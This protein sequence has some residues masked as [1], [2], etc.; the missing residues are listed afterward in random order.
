ME[1]KIAYLEAR[2][3]VLE[4]IFLND[5]E[6]LKTYLNAM[7]QM[8]ETLD[9]EATLELKELFETHFSQLSQILEKKENS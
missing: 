5:V 7:R 6:K 2:V 8:R 3:S 9:K 4:Y 1:S